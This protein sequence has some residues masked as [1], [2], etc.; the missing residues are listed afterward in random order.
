MPDLRRRFS[1]GRRLGI[2]FT[3]PRAPIASTGAF[4]RQLAAMW[5][6]LV[7]VAGLSL[8]LRPAPAPAASAEALT[9]AACRASARADH[10]LVAGARAQ[11]A[12]AAAREALGFA[13]YLPTIGGEASM[14]LADGALAGARAPGGGDPAQT[15]SALLTARQTIWDFGRT[16]NAHAAAE[17]GSDAATAELRAARA[18]RDTEAEAAFRTAVAAAEL[19]TAAT[20]AAERAQA[21]WKR[22]QARV[23]VGQRPRFDLIRAEVEQA[24]AELALVGA[25]NAQALARAQLASACGRTALPEGIELAPPPIAPAPPQGTPDALYAEAEANRPE[26]RAI[27]ARQKAAEAARDAARSQY[28]PSL[29]ANGAW[30]VRG[31]SPSELETG[32]QATAQLTVPLFAGGADQARWRETEANASLAAAQ[33]EQLA[34]TTRLEVDAGRLG[35]VEAQRRLEAAQRLQSAAEEGLRLATARYETGAGDP[36]EMADAQATLAQARATAVRAALDLDLAAVRLARSLGR[37]TPD[38]GAAGASGAEE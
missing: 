34:R 13:G 2:R 5:Q 26:L 30:G 1:P 14:Q 33:A 3:P 4:A 31:P 8:A 6:R 20:E 10:P 16:P 17:A 36:V 21:Q 35:A 27:R 9:L 28:W 11:A 19:V 23:E 18:V 38:A 24:Q 7:I 22:A 15:W 37:E 29:G 12:A 32:W 25:R